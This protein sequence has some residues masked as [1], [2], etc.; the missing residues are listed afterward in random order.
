MDW[1]L[2]VI[3]VPVSDVDRAKRCYSEQLGY[4]VEVAHRAPDIITA[5]AFN[6]STSRPYPRY[7]PVVW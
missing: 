4:S 6:G 2:E 5:S 1:R 7:R 3:V